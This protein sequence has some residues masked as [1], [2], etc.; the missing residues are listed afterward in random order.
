MWKGKAQSVLQT[1]LRRCHSQETQRPLWPAAAAAALSLVIVAESGEEQTASSGS[2]HL[3]SASPPWSIPTSLPL[4]SCEAKP[5]RSAD[6]RRFQTLKR[7]DENTTKESL[8]S[9]Y[10]IDWKNPLGEGSFGA[11][12]LATERRTGEKVAVKKI[13]KKYTNEDEF[14]REM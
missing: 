4:T 11:V 7:M 8:D 10:D 14:Y 13:S 5:R 1:V 9:R 2:E 12:Y 6:V 3:Q